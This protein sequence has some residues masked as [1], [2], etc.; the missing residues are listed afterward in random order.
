MEWTWLLLVGGLVH[1]GSCL[2]LGRKKKRLEV[3]VKVGVLH[4]L[5]LFRDLGADREVPV[6]TR[7]V[8]RRPCA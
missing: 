8:S 1:D 7:S 4:R 3:G 5:V 2:V 6:E